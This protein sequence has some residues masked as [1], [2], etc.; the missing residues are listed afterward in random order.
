MNFKFLLKSIRPQWYQRRLFSSANAKRNVSTA[1]YVSNLSQMLGCSAGTARM[2]LNYNE[3]MLTSDLN[4]VKKVALFCRSNFEFSE[5]LRLPKVLSLSPDVL[6]E[7]T[8]TLRELFPRVTAGSVLSFTRWMQQTPVQFHHKQGYQM[9]LEE[10]FAHT[11]HQ[12]QCPDDVKL[13]MTSKL[14]DL[15][16][17][18]VTFLEMKTLINAIYLAWRFD[19]SEEKVMTALHTCSALRTKSLLGLESVC[20]TLQEKFQL[21]LSKAYALLNFLTVDSDNLEELIAKVPV[22]CGVG[23]QHIV[24]K[25]PSLLRRPANS[26][27]DIQRV[28]ENHNIT[29][30]QLLSCPKILNSTASTIS[31]RLDILKGA[32]NYETLKVDER[33]LRLVF[34][35]SSA[36]KNPKLVEDL[37]VLQSSKMP[38]NYENLYSCGGERSNMRDICLYLAVVFCSSAEGVKKELKQYPRIH[39]ASLG[40]VQKIVEYLTGQGISKEQLWNGVGIVL[41][42]A[43]VVIEYFKK[44][45]YRKDLQPQF[46]AW[47]GHRNIVQLLIYQIERDQNFTGNGMY[48]TSAN[49]VDKSRQNEEMLQEDDEILALCTED[50]DYVRNI[51][52][53]YY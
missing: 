27:I 38:L 1:N 35:F 39:I 40:N 30:I 10:H 49:N 7:R 23:I 36:S 20:D 31:S 11:V 12:L 46:S 34:Y 52:D 9:N 22:M 50:C 24:R 28:L 2:L 41:Y 16:S 8:R 51:N 5:I 4:D 44:L 6:K 45:P 43:E 25:Q 29:A 15:H 14:L 48:M 32:E 19:L 26:I 21:P 13:Q 47:I 53:M 42:D 3:K 18:N 33:F 37:K 17:K